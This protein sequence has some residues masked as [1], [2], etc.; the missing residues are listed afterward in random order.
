MEIGN[1]KSNQTK[2]YQR[3]VESSNE[4]RN[5]MKRKNHTKERLLHENFH[6][7]AVRVVTLAVFGYFPIFSLFSSYSVIEKQF[8]CVFNF[9]QRACVCVYFNLEM[10]V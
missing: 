8:F 2:P 6:H 4:R 10:I 9:F 3:A 5:Q 7:F 1:V